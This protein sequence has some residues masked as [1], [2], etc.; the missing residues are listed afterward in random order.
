MIKKKIELLPRRRGL[1]FKATVL[2]VAA[3]FIMPNFT[4]AFDGAAYQTAGQ[5]FI[6]G[7]QTV[8][9]PE[10]LGSVRAAFQGGNR[11]VIHIQD[12]HC[13]YE[14]Q[15]NI[16]K[17]I[18]RLAQR[19]GL[20]L[21]TVEGASL[22]VNV[23]YLAT[24]PRQ[25]VKEAVGRFFMKQGKMGGDEFYA[26]TG[27]H[28]VD[29]EGVEDARLYQS[30]RE[31]VGEFLNDESQGYIYD[32]REAL[33][34]LQPFIYNAA[35]LKLEGFKRANREGEIPTLKYAAELCA[36]ARKKSVSLAPYPNATLYA[37]HLSAAALRLES[38]AVFEELEH[39]DRDVRERLY[40]TPVQRELDRLEYELDVME[41]ILSVSATPGE[42]QAYF[43]DSA[44]YG[45]ERFAQFIRAHGRKASEMVEPDLYALD[46][47]LEK[48]AR[49][50]EFADRRSGV[51]VEKALQRMQKHK[52][53][54]AVLITG[55]FH[56]DAVLAKLKAQGVSYLSIQPKVTH[57]DLINPYFTL[58]RNRKTPLEKLLSENQNILH[59]RPLQ[60]E[61]EN[62]R[63]MPDLKVMPPLV[64][65]GVESLQAAVHA[66]LL[67]EELKTQ[68]S[69][70]TLKK[71]FEQLLAQYPGANAS[72]QVA[73]EAVEHNTDRT[74]W[75]IPC[76]INSLVKY[77][78]V[79]RPQTQR[80]VLAGSVARFIDQGRETL[81]LAPQPDPVKRDA[82]RKK[83]METGIGFNIG[84]NFLEKIG[85]GLQTALR[86]TVRLKPH[87]WVLLGAAVTAFGAGVVL[88]PAFPW[89]GTLFIIIG[90]TPLAKTLW[91]QISILVRGVRIIAESK[92]NPNHK[93]QADS[94]SEIKKMLAGLPLA[95]LGFEKIGNYP[96]E[97][98][99]EGRVLEDHL[100][101]MTAVLFS[102]GRFDIPGKTLSLLQNR[103]RREFFKQFILLHDL[104]KKISP[105]ME[106]EENGQRLQVY[107][108]HEA[109]SAALI[110]QD[111]NLAKGLPDRELLTEVIR[112]HGRTYSLTPAALTPEKMDDFL[113]DI[114]LELN[115]HEVMRLLLACNYLDALGTGRGEGMLSKVN[116]LAQAYEQYLVSKPSPVLLENLVKTEFGE[117]LESPLWECLRSHK[118][119]ELRQDISYLS[120]H[121]AVQVGEAFKVEY[122]G[123]R[124]NLKSSDLSTQNT[125]LVL[126]FS[127]KWFGLFA[128]PTHELN[129]VQ[130]L[131]RRLL[132]PFFIIRVH[133]ALDQVERDILESTEPAED[134]IPVLEHEQ[135]GKI[136][137]LTLGEIKRKGRPMQAFY[138]PVG[139][140]NLGL[141]GVQL[142]MLLESFREALNPAG[143]TLWQAI[144]PKFEFLR[145]DGQV[146]T[147][148]LFVQAL[149]LTDKNKIEDKFLRMVMERL[150]TEIKEA[151]TDKNPLR[152]GVEHQ[153]LANLILLSKEGKLPK[154]EHLRE[155]PEILKEVTGDDLVEV[156]ADNL[157]LMSRLLIDQTLLLGLIE[158]AREGDNPIRANLE[159]LLTF[160]RAAAPTK[161]QNAQVQALLVK[162]A[163]PEDSV[164]T[165]VVGEDITKFVGAALNG[166]VDILENFNHDRI[167]LQVPK[168]VLGKIF[169]NSAREI[170][171][172][173]K[174]RKPISVS[175]VSEQVQP[176]P[177]LKMH[178]DF[179]EA[180]AKYLR[181]SV[182]F[183]KHLNAENKLA[184]THAV[185]T[186]NP[187]AL[188]NQQMARVGIRML[189]YQAAKL[190]KLKKMARTGDAT[191]AG[192]LVLF[193][194]DYDAALEALNQ[195]FAN[196]RIFDKLEMGSLGKLI[197]FA[198]AYKVERQ[199][200]LEIPEWSLEVLGR[201]W[202]LHSHGD[203]FNLTP[204]LENKQYERKLRRLGVGFNK[205][206]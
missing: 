64:R 137:K 119:F 162:I 42:L 128:K 157:V 203:D 30:S 70:E 181:D 11:V 185:W 97:Y 160:L 43:K 92:K 156:K 191:A 136:Q 121:V 127:G 28:K 69:K 53:E 130:R 107:P 95:Y 57:P 45:V 17:I 106:V 29:L 204:E 32:L 175:W 113:R 38:D 71:A 49:F 100:R 18:D 50:Y 188:N 125:G 179:K 105:A 155:A 98:H 146:P 52:V 81:L 152:Y 187:N 143:Q 60:Q 6:F 165:T 33:R 134:E 54:M 170:V 108:G 183:E 73:W 109:F 23:T 62:T 168:P 176:L 196:S 120:K 76:E 59:F 10:A 15:D 190:E 91:P 37:S 163:L 149:L 24:C 36:L 83:V 103:A 66:L 86:K 114:N 148:E 117:P 178:S 19:N 22:P 172:M 13:N 35:L 197:L 132:T 124:T 4:W 169:G 166:R 40:T 78:L 8:A 198:P 14:V 164:L 133:A 26:S 115:P 205:M 201:L 5:G 25:S 82:L 140:R 65:L 123:L 182:F 195:W 34:E 118:L 180:I 96:L 99:T 101:A 94:F 174:S 56:T 55:G 20:K 12:L 200:E 27:R 63:D 21:V 111:E 186:A 31:L 74:V 184:Q 141:P 135:S 68:A 41:K 161:L 116:A 84:S 77:D 9:V 93:P 171:E 89:A 126:T 193:Q 173:A 167:P 206:A 139:G 72:F 104:G 102:P 159:I 46:G 67:A 3:S 88:F 61:N 80:T 153:F 51:F 39:L 79:L 142:G 75:W 151:H 158:K 110:A 131:Y 194:T 189:K 154:A 47:Y 90:S 7:R 58:L 144:E 1:G 138:K 2:A 112:L 147:P 129:S 16:A 202:K 192:A 199:A 85:E 150:Q 48:A 44:A 87:S 177:L 122:A 145:Q